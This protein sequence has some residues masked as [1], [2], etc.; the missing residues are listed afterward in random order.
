[1]EKAEI[2]NL[3]NK[4]KSNYTLDQQFYTNDDIFDLDLKN[5]FYNHVV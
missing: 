1:M 2:K 4:Q 3:I 5:I